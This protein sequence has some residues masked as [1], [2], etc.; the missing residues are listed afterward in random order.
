MKNVQIVAFI[1]FAFIF[2]NQDVIAQQYD[3]FESKGEIV[4]GFKEGKW[5]DVNK[6]G[7]VYK[8]Y[9]YKSGTPT[10][11]WKT[12][13]PNG[14]IRNESVILNEKILS[15]KI[16]RPNLASVVISCDSGFSKKQYL[17]LVD[18]ENY[19]YKDQLYKKGLQDNGM[20]LTP[21]YENEWKEK[22]NTTIHSL[23]MN[24]EVS[25]NYSNGLVQSL[26]SFDKVK[27][28]LQ[29]DYLYDK[30]D[31]VKRKNFYENGKQTKS[32]FYKNGVLEKEELISD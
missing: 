24:V 31:L 5:V 26:M 27:G 19:F 20:K 1:L 6:N 9:F 13:C 32:I 28:L 29:V 30:H 21:L 7:V 16:Y 8:E 10:G 17:K 14:Q 11:T 15:Y 18:F 12:F 23:Y 3:E 22:L 2:K 4:N 25:L